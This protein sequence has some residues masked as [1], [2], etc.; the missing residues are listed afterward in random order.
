MIFTGP[1]AVLPNIGRRAATADRL[2][3]GQRSD[4]PSDSR[5][6]CRAM[7]AD[8]SRDQSRIADITRS[9]ESGTSGH[10]RLPGAIDTARKNPRDPV[11]YA[12]A[13]KDSRYVSTCR[14]VMRQRVR[15]ASKITSWSA[16][17]ALRLRRTGAT[18]A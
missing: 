6:F 15:C 17:T 16:A 13:L 7:C 10:M 5:T 9:R 18:L 1:F 8:I 2:Y 14:R 12:N 3:R 4:S 11:R